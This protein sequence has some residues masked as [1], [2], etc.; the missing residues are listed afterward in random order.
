M[1]NAEAVKQ[2][3]S[4][5]TMKVDSGCW[6]WIGPKCSSGRYGWLSID[7]NRGMAHRV[8]YEAFVGEAPG[9]LF[10]CH[11]CDNGICVNPDHLF[12]GTAKDNMQDCLRKGRYKGMFFDQSGEKNAHAKPNYIERNKKVLELRRA[13]ASYSE[14][15]NKCGIKSNGHLRNI[16]KKYDL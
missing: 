9:N 15:R 11:K 3:I 6:E 1:K 2:L 4:E 13:G 10:V 16:L 7:G 5:Q 8:S 14:I 12:L